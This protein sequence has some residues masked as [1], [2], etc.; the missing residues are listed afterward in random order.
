MTTV[1]APHVTE[2]VSQQAYAAAHQI[3]ASMDY[4]GVLCIEFFVLQGADHE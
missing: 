1:P 2:A 4:V 3:A